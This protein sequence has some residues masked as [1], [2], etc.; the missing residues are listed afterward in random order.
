MKRRKNIESLAKA[1]PDIAREW[2]YEGNDGGPENYPCNSS[3]VF[4]WICPKG[5]R[6]QKSISVRTRRGDGCPI[7]SGNKIV[8]GVNDLG[9]IMPELMMEWDFERLLH[10]WW[11]TF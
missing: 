3:K 5:H 10:T 9:T 8:V 1:F 4:R 2:D 7:C 6:Y 11:V